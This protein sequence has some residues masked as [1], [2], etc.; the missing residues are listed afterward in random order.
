[1]EPTDQLYL[2][3][4]K[5][6]N[7]TGF[8][9]LYDRYWTSIYS[10]TFGKI[11]DKEVTEEILQNLWIRILENP[12]FIKV[13]DLGSAKSYIFRYLHFRVIDYYNHS[14]KMH[15]VL[16]IDDDTDELF[17]DISEEEYNEILEE[18][19]I[20]ELMLMIDEVVSQLSPTEQ[21]VY[22]LRIR[23]NKSVNETAEILGISSKTVSNNLSKSLVDVRTKLMP[24]YKSS[25]KLVSLLFIIDLIANN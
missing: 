5:S 11:R 1:M 3:E 14:K 17:Y 20:N 25:K 10:Y 22:D 13:D 18:N 15:T 2:K 8:M 6:G 7:R 9:K 21:K 4:I 24:H 12:D 16:S 23:Q 19:E